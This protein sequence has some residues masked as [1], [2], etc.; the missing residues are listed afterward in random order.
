MSLTTPKD[1]QVLTGGFE[2]KAVDNDDFITHTFNTTDLM[3]TYLFSFVAKPTAQTPFLGYSINTTL[4]LLSSFLEKVS[5]ITRK[6]KMGNY[7]LFSYNSLYL[8]KRD[9]RTSNF[10]PDKNNEISQVDTYSHQIDIL[11]EHHKVEPTP[12]IPKQTQSNHQ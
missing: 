7:S 2:K 5:F 4:F 6:S 8:K 9:S 11:T 1:W 10:K 3:S 12:F